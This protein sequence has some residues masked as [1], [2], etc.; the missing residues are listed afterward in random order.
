MKHVTKRYDAVPLR[1]EAFVF[2]FVIVVGGFEASPGLLTQQ[3]CCWARRCRA[4]G[5]SLV[6][7]LALLCLQ[8]A[9]CGVV[10]VGG[11]WDRQ[12]LQAQ[13]GRPVGRLMQRPLLPD[14]TLRGSRS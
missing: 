9:E 5:G 7:W 4:S 8:R 2:F 14:S 1:R 3:R 6:G 11:V 10:V 13:A 12:V